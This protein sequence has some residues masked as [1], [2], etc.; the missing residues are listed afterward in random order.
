MY[1]CLTGADGTG[2]SFTIFGGVNFTS[3]FATVGALGG[4]G[5]LGGGGGAFSFTIFV[6]VNFTSSISLGGTGGGGS[7]F[8]SLGGGGGGGIGLI[9]FVFCAIACAETVHTKSSSIIFF[10]IVISE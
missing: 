7:S 3:S 6:G 8:I 4:C 9:D 10:I 2:L 5:G 1:Y